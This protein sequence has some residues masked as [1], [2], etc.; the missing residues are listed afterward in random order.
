MKSEH[1]Y[2]RFIFGSILA[3]TISCVL[4]VLFVIV[5][6]PYRLFRLVE[7][8][9]FNLVKPAPERYQEEIKLSLAKAFSGN[10]IILGNS[11]AEIGFNPEYAGLTHGGYSAFNL[12]IAGTT[13]A[14]AIRQLAYLK[15]A[16]QHPKLTVLGVEFLDFLRKPSVLEGNK[17]DSQAERSPDAWK[18]KFD[19]VFSISSVADAIETLRIQH[20]PEA[21]TLTAQ[22]FNPLLEY[23]KYAREQG[24]YA[25]FQQRAVEN[26]KKYLSKKGQ[27]FDFAQSKDMR[28]VKTLLGSDF[29]DTAE[30]HV[31]IYPYH[32]QILAMFE[33]VGLW[34]AFETW[35][36]QLAQQIATI[37]KA[38]PNRRI[39]LWDF[40]GYSSYQCEKIP[41]K[42]DKL[43]ATQWYWEAGHF[44]PSLGEKIFDRI[45]KSDQSSGEHS[46]GFAINETNVEENKQRI[47]TERANCKTTYPELFEDVDRLMKK[48]SGI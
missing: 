7:K 15:K 30:I 12:A 8:S 3:L 37:Q 43:A 18:W 25:L 45:L 19:T 29:S 27:S 47:Q 14:V 33:H 4:L 39:T 20:R 21:I 24:Y 23:R 28:D 42:E 5:V 41:S 11:R 36:L 46:F 6:D 40:S 44:K 22:G 1:S 38:H 10:A 35:K 34:Q 16:G 17:N 26:A 32:A 2:S 13:A 9:D 48:A 31:I